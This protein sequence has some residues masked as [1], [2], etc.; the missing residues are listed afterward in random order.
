[1]MIETGDDMMLWQYIQHIWEEVTIEEFKASKKL[2]EEDVL[3]ETAPAFEGIGEPYRRRLNMASFIIFFNQFSGSSTSFAFAASIFPTTVGWQ[4]VDA[5]QSFV[6]LAFVQVVVTLLTG[7]FLEKYGRRSFMMEGQ[8]VIIVANVLLGLIEFGAPELKSLEY[9]LLF[10][11][12][13]GFSLS[14][15]P[16]SFVIIT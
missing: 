16:C 5:V 15:G 9:I 4:A 14:F 12:M 8:R 10:V 6:Y 2:D 11:H 3:S 1:M 13:I 7:Q